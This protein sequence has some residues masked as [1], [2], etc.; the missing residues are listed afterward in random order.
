MKVIKKGEDARESILKGI[1][2]TVDLV[3]V[4]LGGKGRIVQI[5]DGGFLHPTTDGVTVLR[6]SAMDDPVE[7]MGVK[8]L[9]EAAEKQ[10]SENGDGT[11]SV[12]I[13]IRELANEGFDAVSSGVE[14]ITLCNEIEA[15]AKKVVKELQEGATKIGR[16]SKEVFDIAKVSAHGDEEVAKVVQEAVGK[17][18]D[19]SIITV[20]LSRYNK[21]SVNLTKGYRINSG[22]LSPLF[23]TNSR[24]STCE[25]KDAFVMVYE[26]K[27]ESFPDLFP[28]LDQI[29]PTGRPFVIISDRFEGNPLSTFAINS[30]KEEVPF[31]GLAINPFGNDRED[32]R[33][34]LQDLA[35]AVGATFLSPDKGHKLENITLDML[36]QASEVISNNKETFFIGGA[37][38]GLDLQIR[39]SDIEHQLKDADEGLEKE[40]LRARLASIDGG[41]ADIS[42]GGV[43]AS[44]A[45]ERKDR[46][47]DALGAVLAALEFGIVPGGG[48]S[49]LRARKVLQSPDMDLGSQ[50]LYKS[51]SRPFL[52]ITENAGLKG[53]PIIDDLENKSSTTGYDVIECKLVDMIVSGIIDPAK[54]EMNVVRNA[55]SVVT[56][57]LITEGLICR[58]FES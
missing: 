5:D 52:Q 7:D 4:T 17:T 55:T 11:T 16:S 36:G 29:T 30:S 57:F 33:A 54:V 51:L 44:E 46:V 56:N 47:D 32:T 43:L 13:M 34:R 19:N 2:K 31:S 1:N 35:H 49:L 50:I 58:V 37:V 27:I 41:F 8:M 38:K 18:S 15:A 24:K 9:L 26:G 21:T 28:I 25:L 12:S 20:N 53:Q 6:N 10:V 14:P 22:I 3:Q 23:I 40:S 45:V 39:I 42:V 48:V